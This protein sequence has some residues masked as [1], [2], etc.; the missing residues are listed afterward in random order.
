VNTTTSSA[1][2]QETIVNQSLTIFI[3]NQSLTIF[4][5]NQS[6]ARS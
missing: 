4:I 3:V 2:L 6:L 5:V 1:R